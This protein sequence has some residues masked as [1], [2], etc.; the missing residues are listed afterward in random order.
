M[1]FICA[2][3]KFFNANDPVWQADNRGYRYGDGL[4]ETMRVAGAIIALADL[5]FERFF[6]GLA[7]LQF[8]VPALLNK[9]VLQQD[10]IQLCRKNNCAEAARVRLSAFRGNGGLYDAPGQLHYLVECWPLPA[11]TGMLN[12]NGLVIGLYTE[13]RK[14]TDIFSNLK[15][16]NFLPYVMAARY[17][18]SNQLNDCLVL[19][20]AGYIADAT[21]ANLFIIKDGTIITPGT[22]QGCVMG[23]MRRWLLDQMRATGYDVVEGTLSVEELLD[24]DEVFLTNAIAGIRWVKQYE[25]KLYT[26]TTTQQLYRDMITP[27]L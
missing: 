4:F 3:G 23:V 10:I 15:S 7:T 26:N 22:D 16:A 11:H 13:A 9:Q 17:A 27:I 21:I 19:N 5:H 25:D 18:K 20:T 2:D 24:A 14:T 12:E 8:E 1:N 6:A